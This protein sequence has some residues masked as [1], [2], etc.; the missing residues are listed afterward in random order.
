M[1]V[2]INHVMSVRLQARLL[3]PTCLKCATDVVH[4]ILRR[5][6]NRSSHCLVPSGAF[7]EDMIFIDMEVKKRYPDLPYLEDVNCGVETVMF[8]SYGYRVGKINATNFEAR[9][10]E[11]RDAVYSGKYCASK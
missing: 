3:T 5:A 8:N 1:M 6:I 10:T 4:N 7:S 2:S 9:W 11:I